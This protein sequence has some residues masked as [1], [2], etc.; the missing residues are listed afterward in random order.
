MS[1]TS[2]NPF[3]NVDS[4]GERLRV[5]HDLQ[6]FNSHHGAF[7]SEGGPLKFKTKTSPT[8]PRAA[9]AP[10]DLEKVEMLSEL[11]RCTSTVAKATHDAANDASDMAASIRQTMLMSVKDMIGKY[12]LNV[13]PMDELQ[14]ILGLH[15]ELVE[16]ATRDVSV[17]NEVQRETTLNFLQY[18]QHN[19]YDPFEL[20][21]SPVSSDPEIQNIL[22]DIASKDPVY[23]VDKIT[24]S[25]SPRSGA[26]TGTPRSSLKTPKINILTDDEAA[27]KLA[28]MLDDPDSLIN[29]AFH[30]SIPDSS[31]A[32]QAWD[33]DERAIKSA[34]MYDT[35]DNIKEAKA[36]VKK[37]KKSI[38]KAAKKTKAK[39]K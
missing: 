5:M 37:K 14:E 39:K 21:F 19:N 7:P 32:A 20:G 23:E 3:T 2:T 8:P 38:K 33:P 18:L 10:S 6:N 35:V 25:T 11:Y 15:P 28:K 36:Q 34:G 30:E 1:D 4:P 26:S 29:A 12:Q 31:D 13:T 22:N 16:W 27:I 9:E 17:M 24:G